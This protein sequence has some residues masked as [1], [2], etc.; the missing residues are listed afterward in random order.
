MTC[1]RRDGASSA[2]FEGDEGHLAS[3]SGRDG[4]TRAGVSALQA[5]AARHREARLGLLP[6]AR[7]LLVKVTQLARFGLADHADPILKP[8]DP[9]ADSA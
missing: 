8:S 7:R 6:L 2:T 4:N 1:E 3:R 5:G 9:P